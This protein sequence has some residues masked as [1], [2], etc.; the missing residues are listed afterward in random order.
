MSV[1]VSVALLHYYLADESTALEWSRFTHWMYPKWS[2]EELFT[3]LLCASYGDL[4]ALPYEIV[5]HVLAM[6][7][8]HF[9]YSWFH[10]L[11]L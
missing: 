9:M 6:R 4:S 11:S 2:N 8:S 10:Y 3:V 7:M 5:H 1:G